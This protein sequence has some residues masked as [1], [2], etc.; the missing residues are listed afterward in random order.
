MT[1]H[2]NH[3]ERPLVAVQP[4]VSLGF[5]RRIVNP[6]MSMR[7]ITAM[8]EPTVR[9]LA[10]LCGLKSYLPK[11]GNRDSLLYLTSKSPPRNRY[12]SKRFPRSIK[13]G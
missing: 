2:L 5:V 3:S 4:K 11:T 1:I 10:Q 12:Y 6:P 9:G 13:R 7:G 8:W